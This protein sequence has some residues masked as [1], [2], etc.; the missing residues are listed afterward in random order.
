MRP[1][2]H[3][4]TV[5]LFCFARM[6]RRTKRPTPDAH[7]LPLG[8]AER[9]VFARFIPKAALVLLD[10]VRLFRI[11]RRTLT[12]LDREGGMARVKDDVQSFVRFVAA[13]AS[14]EYKEMPWRSA[15]FALAAL[16]YFVSPVDLVPDFIPVLG[17]T[18]DVTVVFAVL[19][20]IRKD[21]SRFERWRAR[22]A[23]S[24]ASEA[25]VVEV[26]AVSNNGVLH[27]LSRRAR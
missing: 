20:A 7:D 17:F 8:T 27:R 9:D 10:R 15:V 5:L 14:G 6:A 2:R 23:A 1:R 21:L 25:T 11:L 22:N 24:L 12:K 18:D 13:F 4:H 3:V 26:E 19:T 16:L